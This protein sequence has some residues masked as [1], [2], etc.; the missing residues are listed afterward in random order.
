M[1]PPAARTP[2]AG[3]WPRRLLAWYDH[4]RRDLPWRRTPSP[5]RT[6]VSELMLQQTRVDTV[7]PYF[8]RF[9]RELPD[10]RALAAVPEQRLLK[11]WEGLGYYRRARHLRA[12]AKRIV[13]D[14]GG[15]FPKTAAGWRDLPGV[16]PYTAAAIASIAFGEPVPVVDG[17]VLRVFTRF[18]ALAGDIRRPAVRDDLAGRLQAVLDAGGDARKRPG[19]FNQAVMELGALVCLPKT[20][21]CAA[22]PLRPDCVAC[23]DDR[24]AELPVK[25]ARAPVPHV[26]IA[27]AVIRRGGRILVQQR[28]AEKMLGG[29]WEFPGGKLE[30]GETPAAAVVREVREETG[31]R[32][33]AGSFLGKVD[34][35]YS[36]FSVTLHVFAC[37]PLP[38]SRLAAGRPGRAG[39][40]PRWVVPAELRSLPMP[41]ANQH[42]LTLLA[43]P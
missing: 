43:I 19:D 10:V 31:L 25:S 41:R 36:H 21:R 29:L 7:I 8:E 26:D 34:H 35:A 40:A 5:Y 18:W 28:H 12:A 9:L 1:T 14:L 4:N 20:P 39:E 24:T 3:A 2:P 11:L 17:N 33:R 32:V 6:W 30:A 27:V 23:R 13:A 42:I 15:K 38:G 22:C 16:G 37:V